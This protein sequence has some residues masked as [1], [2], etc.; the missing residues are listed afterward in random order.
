MF[1]YAY[2]CMYIITYVTCYMYIIMFSK[3]I[4]I[5][6]ANNDQLTEKHI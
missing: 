6:S 2:L 3:Y 5:I 1:T 4:I